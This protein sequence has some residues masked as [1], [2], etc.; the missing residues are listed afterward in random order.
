MMES[1]FV[2]K[3]VGGSLTCWQQDCDHYLYD[4]NIL[5]NTL[6]LVGKVSPVGNEDFLDRPNLQKSRL[7]SSVIWSSWIFEFDHIVD[8][9]RLEF[10]HLLR[11]CSFGIWSYWRLWWSWI[12]YCWDHC[13]LQSVILNLT[14]V[15]MKKMIIDDRDEDENEDKDEDDK[16]KDERWIEILWMKKTW[17]SRRSWEVEKAATCIRIKISWKPKLWGLEDMRM[18]MMLGCWWWWC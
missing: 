10:D 3:I 15:L 17:T 18:L 12:N 5:R 14:P 9:D 6:V 11:L 4:L 13:K 8:Y 7:W 1:V 2:D 16:F